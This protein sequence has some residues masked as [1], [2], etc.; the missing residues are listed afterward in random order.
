MAMVEQVSNLLVADDNI[1]F[2]VDLTFDNVEVAHIMFAVID[3]LN[4]LVELIYNELVADV[5]FAC[6]KP[7]DHLML[8]D[9]EFQPEK[10]DVVVKLLTDIAMLLKKTSISSSTFFILCNVSNICFLESLF[11]IKSSVTF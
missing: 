6:N 3:Y 9:D 1:E 11:W 10:S 4:G 7:Q 8:E 5:D 2:L